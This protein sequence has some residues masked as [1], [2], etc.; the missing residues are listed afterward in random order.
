MPLGTVWYLEKMGRFVPAGFSLTLVFL[1]HLRLV[2]NCTGQEKK[3]LI[4][5]GSLLLRLQLLTLLVLM[6]SWDL[7]STETGG[8]RCLVP[9]A[10]RSSLGRVIS[11]DPTA[12]TQPVLAPRALPWLQPKAGL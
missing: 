5:P 2:G 7:W 9:R 3:G 8:K 1:L 6:S 11:G 10:R 4:P 12:K